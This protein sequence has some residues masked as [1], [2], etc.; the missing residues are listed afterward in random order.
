MM[1]LPA[2]A[3]RALRTWGGETRNFRALS[4]AT[5]PHRNRNRQPQ[6][7][8]PSLPGSEA[9]GQL[10]DS[11]FPRHPKHDSSTPTEAEKINKKHDN[12]QHKHSPAI[13][14]HRN[15]KPLAK[16]TGSP[17]NSKLEAE[18]EYLRA[19][20]LKR[21][22]ALISALTVQ[23]ST[24]EA[25][26]KPFYL[27]NLSLVEAKH[28]QWQEYLPR[29]QPFYA[30]KCNP[31][32][33][34]LG[35]LGGLGTGFDCASLAEIHAAISSG[36]AAPENIIY[37]NPCKQPDHLEGARKLGVRLMTFDNHTELHK[38][39][40]IHPDAELLLRVLVDDSASICQMGQKYGAE[41]AS[42]PSLLAHAR[43]LGLRVRGVSYHVGSGC[44]SAEAFEDAVRSARAAFDLGAEQGYAFDMLDIGG[45][46]PGQFL[47]SAAPA[48]GIS[49]ASIAQSLAPALD[50]YFP[51]DSGG[52]PVE[53]IAEPGRFYSTA[54]HT[55]VTRVIGRREPA[56]VSVSI[57]E[58]GEVVSGEGPGYMYY[59][60]DGLYGSFNCV[61]YDHVDVK[62]TNHPQP[63][64]AGKAK[65]NH[66]QCSLWGPT[67]DGLDCVMMDAQLPLLREGDWLKFRDMGAYCGAAGS[68]FNGF[69]KPSS[70]Y[71]E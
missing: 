4:T 22:A 62:K 14:S 36:G 26:P 42:V 12:G 60:N 1:F 43:R 31:D 20:E 23:S 29:V 49:F 10:G 67:C 33:R 46:F 17:I 13:N 57:G 65:E 6:P 48:G 68:E 52:S 2:S 19:H 50:R 44:C 21:E 7:Q 54:S 18:W 38:I 40:Q 58:E 63:V 35:T 28:Q 27:V 69:E 41:M 15:R 61:M 45:G 25:E 59:I 30:V 3:R 66:Y 16:K 47:P 39:A 24:K 53:I 34:L 56:G 9:T 37:A 8:P 32:A 5:H 71:L 51:E 70:Q 55:L 11:P 64:L